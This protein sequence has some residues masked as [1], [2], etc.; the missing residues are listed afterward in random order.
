MLKPLPFANALAIVTFFFYAAL[1]SLH[2]FVSEKIY[3]FILNAQFGGANIAPLFPGHPLS[4]TL[5]IGVPLTLVV[6]AWIVGYALAHVYN[7]L[8]Q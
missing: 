8:L 3:N 4:W 6:T 2:Y 5:F 7:F 1:C